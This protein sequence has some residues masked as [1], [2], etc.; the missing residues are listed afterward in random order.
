M[1]VFD[2]LFRVE[3][4][5]KDAA[6]RGVVTGLSAAIFVYGGIFLDYAFDFGFFR[7]V[8]EKDKERLCQKS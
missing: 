2:R 1:A 6:I 7:A 4:S 5:F 3:R 8:M